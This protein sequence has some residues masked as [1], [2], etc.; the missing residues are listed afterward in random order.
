ML[1]GGE[2]DERVR[3]DE[4]WQV[5]RGRDQGLGGRLTALRSLNHRTRSSSWMSGWDS[6]SQSE[7]STWSGV[8]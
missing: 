4:R 8:L 5:V 2:H 6:S 3:A 7:D 1:G